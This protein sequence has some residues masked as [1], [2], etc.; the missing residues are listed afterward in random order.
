MD[1]Q[2]F[3][4]RYNFKGKTEIGHQYSK[5]I[6]KHKKGR[7]TGDKKNKSCNSK[8]RQRTRPGIYKELKQKYNPIF[9]F[10]DGQMF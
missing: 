6:T 5:D 1:R 4:K 9:F 2:G 8:F 7:R 10:Y 3:F